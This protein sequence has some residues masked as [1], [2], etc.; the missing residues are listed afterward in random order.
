MPNAESVEKTTNPSF[1]NP[2]A[3]S[4][5]ENEAEFDMVLKIN[6]P[7]YTCA[8]NNFKNMKNFV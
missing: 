7:Q 6:M 8:H 4:F 5:V 3:S 1:K 2:R